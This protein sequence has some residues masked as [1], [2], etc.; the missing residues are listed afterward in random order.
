MSTTLDGQGC[1]GSAY[2]TYGSEVI[3]DIQAMK[4]YPYGYQQVIRVFVNIQLS[5]PACRIGGLPLKITA[6]LKTLR[7]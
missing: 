3:V 2:T 4:G 6:C 5:I 1:T 7:G